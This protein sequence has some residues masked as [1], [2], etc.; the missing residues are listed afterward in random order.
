MSALS[1]IDRALY[2][3]YIVLVTIVACIVEIKRTGLLA[4]SIMNL[5]QDL[6]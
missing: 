2:L 3:D 1:V 4:I 5:I 6:I